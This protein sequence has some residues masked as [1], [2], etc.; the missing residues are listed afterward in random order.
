MKLASMET[1]STERP[2]GGIRANDHK[3]RINSI[4]GTIDERTRGYDGSL[5]VT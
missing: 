5:Y 1:R 4:R 3:R 2:S